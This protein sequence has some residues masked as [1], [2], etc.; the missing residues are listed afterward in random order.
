VK[1]TEQCSSGA[2]E[3]CREEGKGIGDESAAA[4]KNLKSFPDFDGN[5]YCFQRVGC[6]SRTDYP[7]E[8]VREGISGWARVSYTVG[9][10][11]MSR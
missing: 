6:I 7:E 9:K 4:E 1:N 2:V 10:D 5:S 8:A 11:G 3:Y